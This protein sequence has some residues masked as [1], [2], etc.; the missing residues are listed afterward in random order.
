MKKI[1]QVAI[2]RL[3]RLD[4]DTLL[5]LNKIRTTMKYHQALMTVARLVIEEERDRLLALD[6]ADPNLPTKHA[7]GKA[8]AAS[9]TEFMYML[10]GSGDEVERRDEK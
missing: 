3:K 5:A 10:E 1:P 8:R 9:L 7:D 4:K 2:N 6:S